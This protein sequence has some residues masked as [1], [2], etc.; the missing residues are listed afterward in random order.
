M[1]SSLEDFTEDEE[2][3]RKGTTTLLCSTVYRYYCLEL[4][5]IPLEELQKIRS[6]IGTKKFDSALKSSLAEKSTTSFK[7]AN[8]NRYF[9]QH[10]RV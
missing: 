7:R 5:D 8:K 3:I 9:V 1:A 2:A 10:Y 4:G 6:R